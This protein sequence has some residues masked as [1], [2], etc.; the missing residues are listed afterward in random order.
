[1]FLT[2]FYKRFPNFYNA[3]FCLYFGIYVN[4]KRQFYSDKERKGEDALFA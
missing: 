2:H 3:N 4:E 1:M